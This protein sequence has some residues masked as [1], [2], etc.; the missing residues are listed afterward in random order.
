MAGL[1]VCCD[2]DDDDDDD[3]G[4]AGWREAVAGTGAGVAAGAGWS[5]LGLGSLGSPLL[6]PTTAKLVNERERTHR[7]MMGANFLMVVFSVVTK[8]AADLYSH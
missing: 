3:A 1:Y 8:F 2:D 6:C 7:Q 5:V 4:S